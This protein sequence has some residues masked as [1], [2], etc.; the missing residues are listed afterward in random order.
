MSGLD[1]VRSYIPHFILWSVVYIGLGMITLFPFVKRIMP[2]NSD[3]QD[4]FA[5]NLYLSIAVECVTL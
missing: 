4:F 5:S 3:P 1:W 2:S